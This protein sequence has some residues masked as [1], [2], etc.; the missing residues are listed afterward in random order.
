[1]CAGFF[2]IRKNENNAAKKKKSEGGFGCHNDWFLELW[3]KG[4]YK[5]TDIKEPQL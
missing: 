1:M 5:F 2:A 4:N 3:P